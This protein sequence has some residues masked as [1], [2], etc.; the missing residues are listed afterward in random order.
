[1][2]GSFICITFAFILTKTNRPMEKELTKYLKKKAKEF[3]SDWEDVPLW[4]I[5]ES[6]KF[7]ER[8]HPKKTKLQLAIEKAGEYL[9]PDGG[10]QVEDMVK[11]IVNNPDENEI[12]DYIDGVTVWEKVEYSFTVK[13]FIELIDYPA[14]K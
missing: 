6:A 13:Q 4:V 7:F 11:L 9:V 5:T 12:I 1:M 3:K 2:E 10:T 8:K 14:H